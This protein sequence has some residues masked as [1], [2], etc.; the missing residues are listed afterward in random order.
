MEIEIRSR[1]ERR[2]LRAW[3]RRRMEGGM[4]SEERILGGGRRVR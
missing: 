4:V 3:R 2:V 1:G